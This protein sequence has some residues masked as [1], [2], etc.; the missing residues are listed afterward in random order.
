MRLAGYIH[1]FQ[2]SQQEKDSVDHFLRKA[3]LSASILNDL[4]SFRKEFDAHAKAGTLNMMQNAVALLMSSY[5][6]T[7]EEAEHI[8]KQEIRTLEKQA[9][10]EY[11]GWENSSSAVSDHLRLYVVT[12]MLFFGGLNYW[13]SHAERYHCTDLTTAK[14]ERAQLIGNPLSG[15]R[16]LQSYPPPAAFVLEKHIQ[17]SEQKT[18]T[19]PLTN[20]GNPLYQ[21]LLS[22]EGHAASELDILSP[23]KKALAK[24]VSYCEIGSYNSASLLSRLLIALRRFARH[25]ITTSNPSPAREP[26]PD[27]LMHC[28][29]GSN[30]PIL[31]WTSLKKPL[32]FCSMAVYCG[33]TQGIVRP[34]RY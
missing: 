28:G 32:P 23:F 9:L 1:G 7:E 30:S 14:E 24:E 27:S 18:E 3:S 16:R 11:T 4:Y 29:P 13:M 25:L 31:P 8:L 10:D 21:K 2:V 20:G 5:G 12:G 34:R 6:Y 19:K 17:T 15:L 22:I 26:L 33:Y